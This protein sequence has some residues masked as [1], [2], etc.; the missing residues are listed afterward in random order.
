MC[1]VLSFIN[2]QILK[3]FWN[4]RYKCYYLKISTNLIFEFGVVKEIT[5]VVI[6]NLQKGQWKPVKCCQECCS[7]GKVQFSRL[8]VVISHYYFYVEFMKKTFICQN[9]V[10]TVPSSP[11]DFKSDNKW[12][13]GLFQERARWKSCR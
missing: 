6:L 12:Y 13:S 3:L 2:N 10:L 4:C 5:A 7:D 9:P 8:N 11:R 1:T